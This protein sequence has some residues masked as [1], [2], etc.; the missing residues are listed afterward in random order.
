MGD[1][2]NKNEADLKTVK[3]PAPGYN[4]LKFYFAN[5][6]TMFSIRNTL[7]IDMMTAMPSGSIKRR[8]ND[9][10]S[11]T[12]RIYAETTTQTVTSL[13]EKVEAEAEKNPE[14]W[15][16]WDKANLVEMRRIHS[17]LSALPPELYIAS[18]QISNEGRRMH[19]AALKINKWE[20]VQPYVQKVVDLYSKI[21]EHK[22][23]KFETPSKYRSLLMGYASDISDR[24]MDDLYDELLDP[25][26]DLYSKAIEKQKSQEAPEPL[27][28]DFSKADQMWL[29]R[30]VLE[31]M[32]FDFDRGGLYVTNLSPM[33]GGNPEDVRMLVRCGD[34]NNFL[35]SLEDTLYQG[36]RGLN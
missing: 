32:G 27:D 9:I 1:T 21:S 34:S 22:Q 33:T 28:G 24:Q 12:K 26:K 3:E 11:I 20:E 35:D 31:M 16:E 17:H 13:L 4:D 5:L 6:N 2:A 7:A 19:K 14:N 18:V 29:N 15:N 8:I 36:A 23:N 25:L 10:S 30:T